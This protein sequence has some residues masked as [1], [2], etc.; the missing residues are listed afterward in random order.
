M[1]NS[2]FQFKQ[3]LIH[4]DKSAMK[5]TTDSCLFGAW[6]AD[7]L[8]NEN[9]VQSILDI[10]TG[11]GLLALMIAQQTS[12]RIDALE[13]DPSAALQ[14][15][16]NSEGSPFRDRINVIHGDVRETKSEKTYDVI[17]SNPPFYENEL[18]SASNIRNIAHHGDQ[19]KLEELL[20]I[21]KKNLKPDGL[22]FLLLPFKR[23]KELEQ[24]LEN[25]QLEI[26]EK[27]MIR[28]ST[29]HNYF[30]IVLMGHHKNVIKNEPKQS[31]IA[32][33]DG[34]G[35]YTAEFTALLSDYYLNL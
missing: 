27:V 26:A 4:Q 1:K 3:F 12:A 2:W 35:S 9:A 32:I 23:D 10:G 6:V 24:L 33:S 28:Q 18:K 25:N 21:I 34:H 20:I 31:E 16:Q 22:F 5:V 30:R 15:K 19:L 14:A 17:V 11:T 13:L 8:K 7:H 29:G